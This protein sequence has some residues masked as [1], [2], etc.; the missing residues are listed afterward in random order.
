VLTVSPQEGASAS[1]TSSVG[2]ALRVRADDDAAR[3]TEADRITLTVDGVDVS[4][5]CRVREAMTFPRSRLEISY[6]PPA[7]LAAGPHTTGVAWP[8]GSYEW[9]FI[10]ATGTN[11]SR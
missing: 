9:T 8:G 10:V 5:V 1:P 2:A 7:P 3:W 6:V 4:D 11:R